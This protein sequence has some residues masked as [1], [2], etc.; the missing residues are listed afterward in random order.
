LCLD[1]L[2]G[3]LATADAERLVIESRATMDYL[4]DR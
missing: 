3:D 2:V 1:A 4:D